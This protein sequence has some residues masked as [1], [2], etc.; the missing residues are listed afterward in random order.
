MAVANLIGLYL[1]TNISLVVRAGEQCKPFMAADGIREGTGGMTNELQKPKRK[2]RR[3]AIAAVILVGIL[4]G[5]FHLLTKDVD[6]RFLGKWAVT[7]SNSRSVVWEFSRLGTFQILRPGKPSRLIRWHVRDGKLRAVAVIKSKQTSW[8][9]QWWDF[10]AERIGHGD[11]RAV[12]YEIQSAN[13]NEINLRPLQLSEAN[14]VITLTPEFMT[15][16]RIE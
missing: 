5:V 7:S 3:L 4:P 16:R 8:L 11:K 9:M 2:R 13:A 15:L 14:K 6:G 12:E 10:V 1:D